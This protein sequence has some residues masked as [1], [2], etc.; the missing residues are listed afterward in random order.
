VNKFYREIKTGRDRGNPIVEIGTYNRPTE[1]G[2]TPTPKFDIVGWD[3]PEALLP[4]IKEAS[5]DEIPF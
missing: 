5:G 1:Y 4:P 3:N 2:P